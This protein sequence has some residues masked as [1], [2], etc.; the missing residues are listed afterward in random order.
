M[1][2]VDVKEFYSIPENAESFDK[3]FWNLLFS[4]C[5][6]QKKAI[7]MITEYKT[8]LPAKN[9][10]YGGQAF[11]PC[12]FYIKRSALEYNIT[13]I[14]TKINRLLKGKEYGNEDTVKDLLGY[15]ILNKAIQIY[16]QNKQISN[17]INYGD[18]M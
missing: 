11:E 14:Q 5:K 10:S 15:Y 12:N 16:E 13:E 6:N 8:F 17:Y 7:K 1:D 9:I 2:F 3:A 18:E 4:R